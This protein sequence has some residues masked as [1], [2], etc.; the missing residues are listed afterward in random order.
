MANDDM[1]AA[2]GGLLPVNFPFGN[3]KKNYYR[4]TTSA[5]AAFYLGQPVALDATGQVG[6]ATIAAS[7]G[8]LVG[9]IVGFADTNLEAL[10]TG[11]ETTTAGAFLPA[12]TDAYAL[13]ADDPDQEFVIQ[14]D[15]GGSALAR[16][17]IGNNAAMIYRTSSGD[18]TTGYS[19]V[20]LDRS[21]AGTGTGGT[22]IIKAVGGNMNSDGTVNAPGNYCKWIVQ[23]VRHSYAPMSTG[24][25]GTQV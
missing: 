2:R 4:V 13:V 21:S 22:L 10:P 25:G 16:T 11:M 20:E 1:I 17:N 12:N 6:A 19:T 3:F 8:T 15:T 9:S 5:A 14:E 24:P 7:N 23:I 18:N